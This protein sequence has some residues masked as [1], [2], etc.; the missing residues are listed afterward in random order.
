MYANG[1]AVN[2]G[3]A[4]SKQTRNVDLLD[5]KTVLDVVNSN[6]YMF[7]KKETRYN[8]YKKPYIRMYRIYEKPYAGSRKFGNQST[9]TITCPWIPV[10]PVS[11]TFQQPLL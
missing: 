10:C 9:F 11:V 5:S 4:L 1:W 2:L 3:D 8:F 7:S 6:K